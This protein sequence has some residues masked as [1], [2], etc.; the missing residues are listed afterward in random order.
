MSAH[1]RVSLKTIAAP[2]GKFVT[3]PP[4]LNASDH[5]SDFLCGKCSAVLMHAEE[6]QVHGLTLRCTDCGSFN[7]TDA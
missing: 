6:N 7:T 4:I 1:L 5:T 3:A 2:P